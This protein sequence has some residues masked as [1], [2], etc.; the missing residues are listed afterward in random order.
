VQ[1]NVSVKC[2]TD[3]SCRKGIVKEFTEKF[4]MKVAALKTGSSFDASTTQGASVNR[5]GVDKVSEHIQDA[6]SRG[7]K[8]DTGGQAVKDDGFFFQPTVLFKVTPDML[9]A[10]EEK[11]DHWRLFSSL[12]PRLTQ[13]V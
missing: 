6:V 7:A 8:V 2:E 11:L 12:T 1:T 5:A 4:V 3:C 13:Y 9:V 10:R